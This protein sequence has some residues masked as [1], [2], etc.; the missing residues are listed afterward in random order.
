MKT[1]NMSKDTASPFALALKDLLD[2]TNIFTRQEWARLLDVSTPAI[3]QWVRDKTIPRAAALATIVS[4]VR[5]AVGTS[6]EALRAFL[7]IA[8]LPAREVSPHGNRMAPTVMDYLLQQRVSG[9]LRA[10]R[11]LQAEHKPSYLSFSV[12]LFSHL[13]RARHELAPEVADLVGTLASVDPSQQRVLVERLQDSLTDLPVEEEIAVTEVEAADSNDSSLDIERPVESTPISAATTLA[14]D[15][16]YG[17]ERLLLVV[18]G[19]ELEKVL[20]FDQRVSRSRVDFGDT[21]QT[22]LEALSLVNPFHP[23]AQASLPTFQVFLCRAL[24]K[25]FLTLGSLPVDELAFFPLWGHWEFRFEGSEQPFHTHTD[26]YQ[27]RGFWLPGARWEGL[28]TPPALVAP[29]EVGALGLLVAYSARAMGHETEISQPTLD[30]TR[31]TE[32]Q[33][34]GYWRAVRE[35]VPHL[36]G[37]AEP[38]EV[39]LPFGRSALEGYFSDGSHL[40]SGGIHQDARDAGQ[41]RDAKLSEWFGGHEN[42]DYLKD[43][44]PHRPMLDFKLIQFPRTHHDSN[45]REIHL[46]RH[47]QNYEVLVPLDGAFSCFGVRMKRGLED[48]NLSAPLGAFAQE[49]WNRRTV[50]GTSEEPTR[51]LLFFSSE[52]YHG[53]R[54][55]KDRD[56]YALHLRCFD[57]APDRELRSPVHETLA[58]PEFRAVGSE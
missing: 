43:V 45:D 25:R 32:K 3:S 34:E 9:L 24:S 6:N 36:E 11:R 29:G 26:D 27:R 8:G 20:D 10:F 2:E 53:F 13:E 7:A 1:M 28:G 41:M 47:D 5:S 35:S 22:R 30:M 4:T 55:A 38:V 46:A 37:K 56:A 51:D 42:G 12:L 49:R 44:G 50:S 58:T 14:D 52:L 33:V 17:Q 31:M 39:H 21:L 54:G 40:M 16:D 18:R 48:E 15:A 19:R 57:A 23:E